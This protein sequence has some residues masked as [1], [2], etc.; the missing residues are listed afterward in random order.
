[1][2]LFELIQSFK[3][4]AYS[5]KR[6]LFTLRTLHRELTVETLELIQEIYQVTSTELFQI[7]NGSPNSLKQQGKH[8]LLVCRTCQKQDTAYIESLSQQFDTPIGS[9]SSDG[10]I[11]LDWIGCMGLCGQGPNAILDQ[12]IYNAIPTNPF[13][14]ERLTQILAERKQR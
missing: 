6:S 3:D 5:I 8:C 4:Q 14:K 11:S 9:T 13:F 7:I 2:E 10:L 12:K 1:M